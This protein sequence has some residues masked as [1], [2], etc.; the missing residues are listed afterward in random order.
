MSSLRASS[1]VRSRRTAS[2]NDCRRSAAGPRLHDLDL[3]HHA[4]LD[5]RAIVAHELLGQRQR[6]PLHLDGRVRMDQLPV[7][8]PDVGERV[9]DGLIEVDVRDIAV[10]AGNDQLRPLVVGPEAPQQRLRVR[11]ARGR[12]EARVEVREGVGRFQTAAV[13]GH[14]VSTAAPPH[15]LADA[16]VVAAL[17]GDDGCAAEPSTVE[18]RTARQ[19]RPVEAEARR[20][21]GQERRV[22]SG[23]LHVP[24]ERT[25]ALDGDL[26][27]AFEGPLN[28]VGEREIEPPYRPR[29]L[30]GPQRS[31]GDRTAEGG[32][33]R[34]RPR[35]ARCNQRRS[36]NDQPDHDDGG[37]RMRQDVPPMTRQSAWQQGQYAP[38]TPTITARV[39]PHGTRVAPRPSHCRHPIAPVVCAVETVQTTGQ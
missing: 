2:A 10:D 37:N 28:C 18:Q 20:S 19:G 26:P 39:A 23:D 15:P 22:G 25:D 32:F 35:G 38:G 6:L 31:F 30:Y 4:D 16:D 27:V 11:E 24:H 12:G 3:P 9:D 34:L 8:Q 36:G 7:R 14:I 1:L 5:P 17:V 29:V 21:Q 33:E 13:P